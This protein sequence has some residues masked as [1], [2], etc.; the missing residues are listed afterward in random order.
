MKNLFL[1]A[2]AACLF[3]ACKNEK[4][5]PAEQKATTP[6][7]K[8]VETVQTKE[9]QAALTPDAIIQ[10]FKEGNERFMKNDLTQ[11]DHSKQVRN[12]T[13]GQYPKAIVLSCVDSRVPVE[14]VFDKGIGDIFVARVAG[15]IINEDMLGSMEYACG[16][17]GSKVIVVMGHEHC[18][19]VKSAVKDVK[20]GNITP[21]LAKIKP[22][23]ASVKYDGERTADNKDFV[24]KVCH[25]NVENSIAEIRKRSPM[26]KELED[27][28]QIKI[29]GAIYDLDNGKVDFL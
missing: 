26:L 19:A 15:N 22:A 27:K 11:R 20:V 12:T 13:K 23:I 1:I 9:S 5:A 16:V 10:S 7:V 4:A 6:E 18:G 8:L 2:L 17:A 29:V 3:V 21:M 28:G 14:D 24:H 25:S